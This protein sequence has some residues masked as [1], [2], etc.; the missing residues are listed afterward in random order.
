MPKSMSRRLHW[1]GEFEFG[2]LAAQSF[3]V[4]EE[5]GAGGVPAGAAVVVGRVPARQQ[6]NEQDRVN[7]FG[8]V[9]VA[10][11]DPLAAFLAAGPHPGRELAAGAGVVGDH[12]F[13]EVGFAGEEQLAAGFGGGDRGGGHELGDLA[14]GAGPYVVVAQGAAHAGA[15]TWRWHQA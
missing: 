12:G 4:V 9:G 5:F 15:G 6:P 7:G 8:V 1:A 3:G 2:G 11:P 14:D 13:H 10:E